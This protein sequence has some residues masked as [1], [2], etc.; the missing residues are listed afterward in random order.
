MEATFEGNTKPRWRRKL[1]YYIHQLI[2]ILAALFVIA[3]LFGSW[4]VV[5]SGFVVLAGVF[6]TTLI[7]EAGHATGALISGWRVVVFTSWPFAIHIPNRSIV[8]SRRL[9]NTDGGGFVFA[10]PPSQERDTDL[11]W[12]VFVLLGPMF[13][14]ATTVALMLIAFGPPPSFTL[15]YGGALASTGFS[16]PEQ[17]RIAFCLL[18]ALALLNLRTFLNTAVPSRQGNDAQLILN[19]LRK[20]PLA[21]P[22]A[23]RWIGLLV[24]FNIRLRNIPDWMFERAHRDAAVDAQ[25]KLHHGYEIARAFDATHVDPDAVRQLI[26]RYR[27]THGDNDWLMTSDAWLASV[28]DCDLPRAEAAIASLTGEYSE[29]AFLAAT[30]AAIATRLGR[31]SEATGELTQMEAELKKRSPFPNPTF[32]DIRKTVEKLARAH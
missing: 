21:R 32:R 23:E 11:R 22:N 26:D 12:I 28:Y 13:T 10:V 29:P 27:A 19:T 4:L 25:R 30:K 8:T 7:H 2:L 14:L 17:H 3:G 6:L 15:T 1:R 5:T 16:S 9:N 24:K 20:R 18:I 31:D